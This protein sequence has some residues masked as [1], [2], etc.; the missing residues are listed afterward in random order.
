MKIITFGIAI[1]LL[2]CHSKDNIEPQSI[3]GKWRPT[4]ITQNR[5]TDGSFNAWHTINTFMALPILEFTSDGR[6]LRDG[7]P[8]GEC[9]SSGNKYSVSGDKI[10]FDEVP[11]CANALCLSCPTNWLI[12][13]IKGDTLILETC[14]GRNKYVKGK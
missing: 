4:Y 5:Q 9:C 8:G 11:F 10:I 12:N 3:V 13:E 14:N 2:A 6:F 7:Q 1:L